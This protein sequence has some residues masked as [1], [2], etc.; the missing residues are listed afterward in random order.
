MATNTG[1][2]NGVITLFENKIQQQLQAVVCLLHLNELPLRKIMAAL[3]GP[4]T[5]SGTIGKKIL[6]CQNLEVINFVA[7][8]S[9]L[10]DVD[11]KELRT[12]QKYLYKIYKAVSTG[13]CT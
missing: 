5:F 8:E 11:L 6:S 12:D 2:S 9:D 7:I 3:D 1:T 10:P 4:S 13:K